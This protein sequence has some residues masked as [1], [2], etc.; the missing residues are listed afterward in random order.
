MLDQGFLQR[1]LVEATMGRT[2]SA[3]SVIE[4]QPRWDR[5]YGAETAANVSPTAQYG[6]EQAGVISASPPCSLASS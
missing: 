4:C 3:R 5:T 1:Y 6:P 2:T